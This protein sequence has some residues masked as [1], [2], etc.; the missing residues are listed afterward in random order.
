VVAGGRVDVKT[1]ERDR[2]QGGSDDRYHTAARQS[3]RKQLHI[4]FLGAKGALCL[5][6]HLL[7]CTTAALHEHVLQRQVLVP[8]TRAIVSCAEHLI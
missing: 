1:G 2:H 6:W 4:Q 8:L 7:T 5:T 3:R